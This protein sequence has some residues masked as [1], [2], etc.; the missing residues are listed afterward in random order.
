MQDEYSTNLW[1]GCLGHFHHDNLAEYLDLRNV[2]KTGY[3]TCRIA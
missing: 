3:L 1:H 2:N